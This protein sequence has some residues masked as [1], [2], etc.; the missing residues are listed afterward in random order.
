MILAEGRYGRMVP[1][2]KTKNK[3]ITFERNCAMEKVSAE[4]LKSIEEFLGFYNFE[5]LSPKH[6]RQ[7]IVK[8][9]SETS[10]VIYSDLQ[11]G[12]NKEEYENNEIIILKFLEK[13]FKLFRED[14]CVVRRYNEK[15]VVQ[16][17]MLPE[18]STALTRCS[19]SNT[20]DGGILL[21]KD[22]ILVESFISSVLRYNSFVEFIFITDEIIVSPTDHMDVFIA[23]KDVDDLEGKILDRIS[24]WGA[25][26]LKLADRL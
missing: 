9:N 15:W 6:Q 25:D 20:F 26:V 11:F 2:T 16:E 12:G 18:L 10:P 23:S 3:T 19:I 22:E 21:K 5:E 17:D 7:L 14:Y 1:K 13:L 8:F 24:A 4:E